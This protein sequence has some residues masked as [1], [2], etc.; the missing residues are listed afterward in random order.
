MN[1]FFYS[2]I[3][4]LLSPLLVAYL[5]FRAIKSPAYRSRW[6]ERFGLTRLQPTDL[7]IHSVSMGE[8]LAAIPLIRQ[9]QQEHPQLCITVTTSSPTGS[10]EVRKA[11]GDS[12]QHCYLPFD[13]PWCVGRFLGQLSPKWLIIM[14]TELWPNL[15]AL[16]AKRG[17]RIM[18]ANGRLSAKSAASYAKRGRLI[19]PMLQRLSVLA[20]QTQAEAERF[21]DLG[22]P[23][24]NLVVC[25]SLKF[26]LTITPE[27][28]AAA[29]QLRR[30][31]GREAAPIWVAG[32]VHPGEFTAVLCAH[33]QLLR[34]WP[35]AL[36]ILAPRH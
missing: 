30:S 11:F 19:K 18:L 8:T 12:V 33:K 23:A 10:A 9:I 22:V 15:I 27:R 29:A 36:L 14:E 21:I 24:A 16:A 7:L 28:L 32:S 3:L 13:L 35:D 31:W 5:A 34:R 25:G 26:D 20:V 1:R 17:V 6:G 4:Y 2:A